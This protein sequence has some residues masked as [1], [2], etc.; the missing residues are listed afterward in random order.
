M[1]GAHG[2]TQLA[3]GFEPT[4]AWTVPGARIDHHERP[5]LR[6]DGDPG[7]RLDA[8]EQIVG[9]SLERPGV[10][11]QLGVEAEHMRHRHRLVLVLLRW[12]S[13]S[14]NRIVRCIASTR[15]SPLGSANG[16]ALKGA[17]R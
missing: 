16:Q 11:D 3:V 8:G 2:H 10:E 1:A 5:L 15:Y 12:R 13:T 14:Q 9:G 4:D 7:W 6:I 17:A